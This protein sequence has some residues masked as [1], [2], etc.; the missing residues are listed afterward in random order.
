MKF[1]YC[2]ISV[3]RVRHLMDHSVFFY[4]FHISSLQSSQFGKIRT[5]KHKFKTLKTFW[6][7]ES[8]FQIQN[9]S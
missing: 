2:H 6:N 1:K 3:F 5:K 9:G 8:L 4:S 7:L